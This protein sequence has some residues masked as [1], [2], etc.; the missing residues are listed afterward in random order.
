MTNRA[1]VHD[2]NDGFVKYDRR[3][4]FVQQDYSNLIFIRGR[5][6]QSKEKIKIADQFLQ[7]MPA[8][9]KTVI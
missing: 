3:C 6:Y 4:L 8:R 5:P 7:I 9:P 2:K 1:Q